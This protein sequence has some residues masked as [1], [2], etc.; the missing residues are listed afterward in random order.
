MQWILKSAMNIRWMPS[1]LMV[2]PF[3][4]SES[5]IVVQ[6]LNSLFLTVWIN[7]KFVNRRSLTLV[8]MTLNLRCRYGVHEGLRL[9]FV[10]LV[11]VEKT[12]FWGLADGER[13]V[14][15]VHAFLNTSIRSHQWCSCIIYF[16]FLHFWGINFWVAIPP[17][18]SDL[19]YCIFLQII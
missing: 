15:T 1:R 6:N 8:S 2:D 13:Q 3:I 19:M 11:D 9:S 14:C 10:S 16:Q 4:R 17:F 5:L 12:T 7:N 18:Y